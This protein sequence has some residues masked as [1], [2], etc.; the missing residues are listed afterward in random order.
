MKRTVLFSSILV[1]VMVLSL[2]GVSNAEVGVTD[3][4]IVVGSHLDLSGPISSW[5]IYMKTGLEMK[6][7][8]INEAGGIHG[9]KIRVVIEDSAYDPKK[10]IMVTN[11][12]I[13][14]DKVFAFVCN[15]GT[16]TAL[17]TKSIIS[18]NKVP[19]MYPG[20]SALKLFEPYDRY[21]F[22]GDTP[23]YDQARAVVKYFVE[24]KK[25]TQFGLMY[26]D[27]EY[28]ETV[29]NGVEDQLATYKLKL[30][31][32]ESYK[33]G[34]TE[35]SSQIT[36]LR[37][38]NPQAL[39]LGTV[40]RESVGAL[41]EA[42]QTGWKIDM[43]GLVTSQ[44]KFVPELCGKAGFSAD[45]YYVAALTPYIYP[46]SPMKSVRDAWERHVKWFGKEPDMGIT[47]AYR[48]LHFFEE[49]AKRAGRDLT[50]EKFIDAL[51]TFREVPDTVFGGAPV[52][53]T[54]KNH[55]GGSSACIE[56]LQG[57]K[58]VKVT[59]FLDFRK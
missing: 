52:T 25:Y 37:K 9:R 29:K 38:V 15:L 8:E 11:K 27:D 18:S 34:A 53:Y 54:S 42:N 58:F 47:V 26:Q 57:G 19:Q 30:L 23:Y 7:R 48:A 35:F 55:Q 20:A 46:D 6:A 2:F 4:E 33:R 49:A 39:I 10:A 22:G 32:A 31:G 16:P 1:G 44:T 24:H 45:G 56:Q 40:M 59:D 21:A 41:K 12:M 43:G 50:R 17:A 14:R 28:G 51:E 13:S 36:K 5:G 3:N